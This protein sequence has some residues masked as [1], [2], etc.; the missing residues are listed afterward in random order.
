MKCNRCQAY[1]YD[2]FDKTLKPDLLE[3]I[4]DHL[5][6]CPACQ[7]MYDQERELAHSFQ[8]TAARLNDRLHFQFQPLVH[9]GKSRRQAKHPI[10]LYAIQWASAA[11]LLAILIVSAKHYLFSPAE[12]PPNHVA[13]VADPKAPAGSQ[14]GMLAET[15]KENGILQI[16]S[17]EDNTGNLAETHFRRES[18]GVV[19]DITVEVTAI[20]ELNSPQKTKGG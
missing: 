20:R 17:I 7:K 19:T 18:A 12:E 6:H 1:L 11:V 16:I 4:R 5:G 2:Y 15:K 13:G 9:S 10:A 8:D 3:S 14:L